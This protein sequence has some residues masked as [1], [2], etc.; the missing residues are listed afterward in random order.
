MDAWTEGGHGSLATSI[1]RITRDLTIRMTARDLP[2]RPTQH[3]S[4]F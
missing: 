3:T 4:N 2:G 1:D